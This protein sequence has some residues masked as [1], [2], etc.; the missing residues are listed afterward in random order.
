MKVSNLQYARTLVELSEG[1]DEK[2][3]KEI[4]ANFVVML[5]RNGD[6]GRV[7]A[8]MSEF[9]KNWNGQM[10][11]ISAKVV[12]ASKLE[13]ET[14]ETLKRYIIEESGVTDVQITEQ[15]DERV[16][17]G[18]ILNFGDQVIDASTLSQINKFKQ[19]LTK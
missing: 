2:Q 17:S 18:F 11:L 13:P 8:I 7:E 12:S 4:I 3:L 10:G 6:I 9:E 14:L 1:K 16:L 19:E 15:L 5:D